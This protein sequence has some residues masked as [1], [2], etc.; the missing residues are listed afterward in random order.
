M[1]ILSRVRSSVL[2]IG[3]CILPRPGSP[4]RGY[5]ASLHLYHPVFDLVAF[6]AFVAFDLIAFV[7][8]VAFVAFLYMPDPVP[9]LTDDANGGTGIGSNCLQNPSQLAGRSMNSFLLIFL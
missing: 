3:S 7:A 8:C 1:S 2:S 6:V 5:R 4:S 9:W